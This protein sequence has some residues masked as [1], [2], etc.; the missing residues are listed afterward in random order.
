MIEGQM[1]KLVKD[2]EKRL[3]SVRKERESAISIIDSLI[4]NSYNGSNHYYQTTSNNYVGIRMY[5]SMATGLA[6]ESSDV[7]LAVTGFNFR[8]SR[9]LHVDEMS[10]LSE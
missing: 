3:Q 9:D 10:K 4:K 8:G 6:I 2:I 5:G 1:Y 7:D